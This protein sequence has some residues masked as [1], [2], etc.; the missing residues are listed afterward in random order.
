M[1]RFI[2][3]LFLY[4][5]FCFCFKVYTLLVIFVIHFTKPYC[6]STVCVFICNPFDIIGLWVPCEFVC[7]LVHLELSAAI[8]PLIAFYA[9]RPCYLYSRLD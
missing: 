2:E 9:Y 5:I 7:L 6:T 3:V 4:F 8:H 1:P